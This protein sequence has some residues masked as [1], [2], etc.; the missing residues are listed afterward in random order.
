MIQGY[1]HDAVVVG[2]KENVNGKLDKL[3]NDFQTYKAGD[4]KWKQENQPALDN[5]KN[6]TISARTI[7]WVLV[8][9]GG[10]TAFLSNLGA[11]ISAF[12]H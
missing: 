6:L 1:I 12:K 5:M 4:E 10:L 3:S 8:S 9:L 2:I 11:I 7:L